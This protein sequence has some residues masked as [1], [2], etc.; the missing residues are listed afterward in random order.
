MPRAHRPFHRPKRQQALIRMRFAHALVRTVLLLALLVAGTVPDG[1]MRHAGEG[2]VRLVLCTGD[3]VKEVW[4]NAD[5]STAPAET[6][7]GKNNGTPEP[8]CVQVVLA[9]A[10]AAPILPDWHGLDLR[11]GDPALPGHQILHRQTAG[12]TRRSRAPPIP[13]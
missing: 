10:D 8:H 4:L 12:D 7:D 9:A 5:G 2:G 13:T 6:E 3:G 1:M 11:S